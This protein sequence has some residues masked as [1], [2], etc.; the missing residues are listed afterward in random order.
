MTK[1]VKLFTNFGFNKLKLRRIYANV[2]S[3]NGAS[4]KVLEKNG[5]KLEGKMKNY[6]IKDGK[7]TDALLYA[8]TK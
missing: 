7:L 8:K 1:A 2:F 5:Y 6:H 3:I 4:A